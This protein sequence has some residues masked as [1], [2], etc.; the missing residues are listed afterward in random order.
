M[1]FSPCLGHRF[2]CLFHCFHAAGCWNGDG[3][4]LFSY[5][6]K[7]RCTGSGQETSC[8]LIEFNRPLMRDGNWVKDSKGELKELESWSVES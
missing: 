8:R 4:L 1:S 3:K 5:C 7:A 6:W 2:V